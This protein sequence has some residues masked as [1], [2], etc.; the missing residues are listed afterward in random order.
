MNIYICELIL[1]SM[2][3]SKCKNCGREIERHAKGMCVTCYKKLA[4]NPKLIK[5]K[6]CGRDL[7]MHAKG[8]CAGCYNSVFHI[9]AVKQA[10][11]RNWYG[12]DLETYKKVTKECVVCGFNKIVDLHHLDKNTSNNSEINLIGLCPNHHRM[13]HNRRFHKEILEALQQRGFEI[14]PY[15]EPDEKFKQ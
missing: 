9:D 11:Y 3:V 10:N 4:W 1:H 7:P 14:S 12:L 15:F 13:L 2:A 6:R 8:L 5:C